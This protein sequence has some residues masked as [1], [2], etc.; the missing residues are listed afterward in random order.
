MLQRPDCSGTSLFQTCNTAVEL[1]TTV[2]HLKQV[3]VDLCSLNLINTMIASIRTFGLICLTIL[4]LLRN[5]IGH[6]DLAKL[7]TCDFINTCILYKIIFTQRSL[8][9][10]LF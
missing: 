2:S 3:Y 7:E 9:D 10:R 6:R 1:H 4:N 5:E 8:C